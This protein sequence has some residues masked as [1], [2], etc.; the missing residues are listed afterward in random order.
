LELKSGR[1]LEADVCQRFVSEVQAAG[2][3]DRVVILSFEAARVAAVKSAAP[4]IPTGFIT[5]K[6]LIPKDGVNLLGP[7]WPILLINPFYV[8]WAHRRGQ[9][10]CPLDPTPDSRL[11]LYRALGC[12]AIL[13]NDPGATNRALGRL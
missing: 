4:S 7:F 12:D 8:A 5:I 1:F 13:T 3:L 2:M 11:W 9:P 10:V 6:R